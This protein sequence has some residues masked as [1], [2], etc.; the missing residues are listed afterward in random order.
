MG[1]RI[2][3]TSSM[4]R[5]RNGIS[6]HSGEQRRRFISEKLRI[7]NHFPF[8]QCQIRGRK[9]ACRGIITPSDGCDSYKIKIEYKE[10]GVP[11]VFITAPYIE[12]DSKYH[13]FEKGGN[14]CLFDD[15]ESPWDAKM[16]IHETIIPWTAEWLVFYEIWKITGKWLGPEAPHGTTGK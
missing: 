10:G 6:K 9:L 12:P 5:S 2:G 11:K 16:L 15:R 13:I 8:F 14:L 3:L 4:A 7:E 1:L